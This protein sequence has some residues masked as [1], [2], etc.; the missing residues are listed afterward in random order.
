MN[1]NAD[2]AAADA[3]ADPAGAALG[4]G[5]RVEP[6]ELEEAFA[7]ARQVGAGQVAAG[8]TGG[9]KPEIAKVRYTHD[10][11]IDII[12]ENPWVS[13][14]ELAAHFGYSATWVSIVINSDAFKARLAE[15]K[16]ELIDPAIRASL[17]ERFRAVVHRSLTVLQEKLER[18]SA[19]VPDNLVLKAVELGAKALNMGGNAQA[20][21][22][23]VP[24][25]H[26]NKLAE[27]LVSLRA[28]ASRTLE[29]IDGQA[30]EVPTQLAA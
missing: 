21:T 13:Q 29:V 20:P 19:M 23:V 2:S 1:P 17:E 16:E 25:D 7:Q 8:Q 10:A 28:Q 4:G 12:V 24:P 27:R 14:D 15:R 18:P 26:L 5:R 6:I 11:M 22:F 30:I 3:D 9:R